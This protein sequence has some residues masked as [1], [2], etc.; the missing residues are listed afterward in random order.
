MS[1]LIK[2]CEAVTDEKK[3]PRGHDGHR[4]IRISLKSLR[5]NM[6]VEYLLLVKVRVNP[7][8]ECIKQSR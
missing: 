1:G 3:S 8:N 7:F 4:W 6:D 5:L 2:I